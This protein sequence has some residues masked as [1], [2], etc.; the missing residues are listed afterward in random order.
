MDEK[1]ALNDWLNEFLNIKINDYDHLPDIDLYI[2]QVIKY[3]DAMMEPY[4]DNL[5]DIQI[6][7]NMINNYV[8]GELIPS[9]LKK[10]YY[11]EHLSRIYEVLT[12]KKVLSMTEVKQIEDER[13]TEG[14][15]PSEVYDNF[16]RKYKTEIEAITSDTFSK[17][18]DIKDSDDYESYINLAT[19]YAMISTIYATIS[20]KILYI[21]RHIKEIKENEL[22]EKELLDEAHKKKN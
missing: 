17:L 20:K 13:Y 12:L 21:T 9:P 10:I 14:T 7:S 5:Q 11:R 3:V 8:K 6:T 4:K 22:K 18:D 2:N 15:K 1:K 19:E 16:N